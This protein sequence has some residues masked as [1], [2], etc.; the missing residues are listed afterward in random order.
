MC[1][2]LQFGDESDRMEVFRLS[3]TFIKFST[4][5]GTVLIFDEAQV[6]ELLTSVQTLIFLSIIFSLQD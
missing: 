3:P 2:F 1:I 6:L 5:Y 4:F